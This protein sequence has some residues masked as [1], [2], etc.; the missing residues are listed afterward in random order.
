MGGGM[1]AASEPGPARHYPFRRSWI[2]EKLKTHGSFLP[3]VHVEGDSMDPTMQDRDIVLVDTSNKA[4]NPPGIFV[5]HD[6]VALVAKRLEHLPGSDPTRAH[7]LRHHALLALRARRWRDQ[8][9]RPGPLVR[10]RDFS[11]L[12]IK[13]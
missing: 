11:K 5:L 13:V 4:P 8:H 10:A 6:G 12:T 1:T 2:W 7:H 3:V 9:H